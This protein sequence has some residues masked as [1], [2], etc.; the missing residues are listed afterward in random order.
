MPGDKSLYHEIGGEEAIGA[1]VDEFYDRVLADEKLAGYFSEANLDELRSHQTAF[2]SAVT[3]GPVEYD[4][5][6][7]RDAHAHLDLTN[8]DFRRVAGHLRESLESFDVQ[9][10]HVDAILSEVAALES[11]IVAK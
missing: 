11:D 5:D 2:I 7:M 3:G 6:D 1:V 10:E 8:D 9:P 4:G